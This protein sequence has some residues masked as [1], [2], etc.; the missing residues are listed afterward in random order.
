MNERVLTDPAL[1]LKKSI[2]GRNRSKAHLETHSVGHLFQLD[3]GAIEGNHIIYAYGYVKPVGTTTLAFIQT[4][5]CRNW[6]INS[7]KAV[8]R[9]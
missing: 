2:N 8:I 1:S 3:G 6:A 5:T 7:M 9:N 4:L